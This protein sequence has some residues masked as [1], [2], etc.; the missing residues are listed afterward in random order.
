MCAKGGAPKG[1]FPLGKFFAAVVAAEQQEKAHRAEH[2]EQGGVLREQR[3]NGHIGATRQCRDHGGKAN[4]SQPQGLTLLGRTYFGPQGQAGEPCRQTGGP[5]R[6]TGAAT[7]ERCQRD[8]RRKQQGGKA[9]ALDTSLRSPSGIFDRHKDWFRGKTL[10][11][12]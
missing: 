7:A 1:R 5:H 11:V 2:A 6:Q 4:T 8:H 10:R 12:N 3:G 9:L